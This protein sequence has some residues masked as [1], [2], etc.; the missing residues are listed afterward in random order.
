[1]S[2]DLR[3]MLWAMRI[4]VAGDKNLELAIRFRI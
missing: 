1:M 3:D 2:K 4:V